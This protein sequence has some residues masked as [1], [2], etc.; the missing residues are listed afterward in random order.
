VETIETDERFE[1]F[2]QRS[3]M[4]TFP[5]VFIDGEVLGGYEDLAK[6]SLQPWF[7]ALA[8]AELVK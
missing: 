6:V 8:K 4:N 2:R 7:R 5:Q 1:S 3:G